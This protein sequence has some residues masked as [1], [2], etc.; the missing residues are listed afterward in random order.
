[1]AA[2]TR[3][4]KTFPKQFIRLA[5]RAYISW[6][7]YGKWQYQERLSTLPSPRLPVLPALFLPHLTLSSHRQPILHSPFLSNLSLP[8]SNS[9]V[10]TLTCWS[11][12]SSQLPLFIYTCPNLIPSFFFCIVSN[13]RLDLYVSNFSFAYTLCFKWYGL[14][15]WQMFSLVII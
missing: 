2:E 6:P 14:V 1:M 10:L 11:F 9:P 5:R 4:I 7:V 8:C 13:Y 3:I 12:A 15:D